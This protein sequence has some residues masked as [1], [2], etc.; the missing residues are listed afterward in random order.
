M[1]LAFDAVVVLLA[2]VVVALMVVDTVV[3]VKTRGMGA[4][5]AVVMRTVNVMVIVGVDG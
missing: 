5:D 1:K 3:M 2:I 4:V